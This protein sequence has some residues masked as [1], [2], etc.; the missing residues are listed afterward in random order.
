MSP[1]VFSLSPRS[2][3]NFPMQ[4]NASEILRIVIIGAVSQGIQ[5][6]APVHDALLI[7]SDLD[8]IEDAVA[9]TVECMSEAAQYVLD[10]FRLNCDVD[11][12]RWPDRYYDKRGAAMWE[13]VMKLLP[14]N[15]T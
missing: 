9:I 1:L 5:L 12:I 4:T 13:T 7:E 6:C 2:L 10:G 15:C 3:A 14:K 11:V 8:S